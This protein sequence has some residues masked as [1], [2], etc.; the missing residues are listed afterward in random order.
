[1]HA[2]AMA[3]EPRWRCVED[4]A[5]DEAAARR[6]DDDLLLV[7]GRPALGQGSQRRPF[8]LDPLA[9]VGVAPANDLVDEA[10]VGI[11]IAEVTAATQE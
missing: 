7:I 4:A 5:Q 3:D 11:Q 6:H 1:V 8:Q 10:A 9:I 2:Q